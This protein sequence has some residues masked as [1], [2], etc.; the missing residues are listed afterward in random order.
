[1]TYKLANLQMYILPIKKKSFLVTMPYERSRE[2]DKPSSNCKVRTKHA[3]MTRRWCS[4]DQN[5]LRTDNLQIGKVTN[6][7]FACPK[8]TAAKRSKA[9][10]GW[11]PLASLFYISSVTFSQ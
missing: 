9:S 6:V 5:A 1:M 8:D 11:P 7:H 3:G 4:A 2:I 10:S